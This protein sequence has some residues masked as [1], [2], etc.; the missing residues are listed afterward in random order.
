MRAFYNKNTKKITGMA[1]AIILFVLLILKF[2]I[3]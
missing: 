3:E 2:V 1:L